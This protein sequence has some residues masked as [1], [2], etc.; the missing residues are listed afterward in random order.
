MRDGIYKGLSVRRDWKRLLLWCEREADRGRATEAAAVRAI[1]RD[2]HRE[3]SR[4][5]IVELCAAA[6]SARAMLPGLFEADVSQY[7][8][9]SERD[10]TPFEDILTRSFAR[11]AMAGQVGVDL[12]RHSFADGITEWNRRHHKLIR[13]NYLAQAGEHAS[14]EVLSALNAA[15]GSVSPDALAERVLQGESPTRTSRRAVDPDED[16]R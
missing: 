5:F 9:M 10:R 3:V 6:E 1:E 12:V 13:E 11:N 2:L 4:G 16:L 14:R 15:L 8:N 7:L